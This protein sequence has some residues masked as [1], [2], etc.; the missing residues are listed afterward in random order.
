MLNI[1][2]DCFWCNIF[3][4]FTSQTN[5]IKNITK[6]K[7]K[8]PPRMLF[9]P[10]TLPIPGNCSSSLPGLIVFISTYFTTSFWRK[11]NPL[12]LK[13]FTNLLQSEFSIRR[14][15]EE[16]VVATLGYK[17]TKTFRTVWPELGIKNSPKFPKMAQEVTIA[18]LT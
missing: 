13:D 7:T 1:D 3:H 4:E 14:R 8:S 17:K 10:R 6:N 15:W 9:F 2:F 5:L 12:Y 11:I 16:C 18:V